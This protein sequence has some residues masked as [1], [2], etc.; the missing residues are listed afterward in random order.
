M[1]L[2]D[3]HCHLNMIDL[4]KFDGSLDN[5]V[6][7]AD[8]NQVSQI[9]NISVNLSSFPEILATAKAYPNVYA[10]VGIHPC[11]DEEPETT[12]EELTRLAQD[13]KVIGIGECGL[14]YHM[15]DA[16]DPKGQNFAWQRE[17]FA[18]HIE[19]AKQIDMPLIIHTRDAID[20]T[21]DIMRAESAG[22]AGGIMHCYVEDVENAKKAMDLGFMI[23]FS[24]IVTFKNAKQ[25]HEVAKMVP[26]DRML[27]ETDSPYLAPMP[28]RGKGN[29]PAYVLH[30]AEHL[31][32]LRNTTLEHIAEVSTDNFKRLF[33]LA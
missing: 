25:L 11:Y 3:S 21:L 15:N 7:G 8:Q 12:V 16:V 1:Q 4:K 33:R 19:A 28:Y 24:G 18:T 17:R 13:E 31:A 2:I 20:D 22:E 30:V 9:L 27:I 14:D 32:Q 6:T 23:S 29:Q 26:D 10:T 5:V